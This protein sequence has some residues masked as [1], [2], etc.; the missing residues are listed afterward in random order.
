MKNP[1]EEFVIGGKIFFHSRE[2]HFDKP[3]PYIQRQSQNPRR[4]I[5]KS[6]QR[7]VIKSHYVS[8]AHLS[9]VHP[10]PIRSAGNPI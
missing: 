1:L 2:N 5:R 8:R 4:M 3:F 9:I 10:S 6:E 7:H